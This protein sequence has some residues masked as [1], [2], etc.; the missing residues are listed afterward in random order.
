MLL[1]SDCYRYMQP[2]YLS[3]NVY[4]MVFYKACK[5]LSTK[6]VHTLARTGQW[7]V[8]CHRSYIQQ[9]TL[10]FGFQWPLTG[11]QQDDIITMVQL[12]CAPCEPCQDITWCMH[13]WI[14]VMH[15]HIVYII[16]YNS[17]VQQGRH[18]VVGVV[19]EEINLS[20]PSGIIHS[21][22]IVLVRHK[23]PNV[24]SERSKMLQM[25]FYEILK[26]FQFLLPYLL[27]D[28]CSLMRSVKHSGKLATSYS[29][30]SLAEMLRI[31]W[32]K[33]FHNIKCLRLCTVLLQFQ[34]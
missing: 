30:A 12:W 3:L 6:R 11:P 22:L 24:S 26:I 29:F 32:Q 18:Q 7:P 28:E 14:D 5:I 4:I 21:H 1:Q 20:S 27:T 2:H 16:Q 31:L 15:R 8:C 34:L 19:H 13:F 10:Q 9:R 23:S 33:T 25:N 17:T